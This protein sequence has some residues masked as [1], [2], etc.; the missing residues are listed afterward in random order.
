MFSV[1]KKKKNYIRNIF[2][3]LHF[4]TLI[5]ERITLFKIQ[6]NSFTTIFLIFFVFSKIARKKLSYLWVAIYLWTFLVYNDRSTYFKLFRP[7]TVHSRIS[8]QM[9]RNFTISPPQPSITHAIQFQW[10]HTCQGQI[11]SNWR[12]FSFGGTLFPS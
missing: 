2:H 7:V 3:G 5:D 1:S 10:V 4:W 12:L 8:S 9:S 6:N 11:I